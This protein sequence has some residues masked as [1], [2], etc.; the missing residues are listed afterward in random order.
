[1]QLKHNQDF[2]NYQIYN[3]LLNNYLWLQPTTLFQDVD[4]FSCSKTEASLLRKRANFWGG[5]L[6]PWLKTKA[7]AASTPG[8]LSQQNWLAKK[9]R[10]R[11]VLREGIVSWKDHCTVFVAISAGGT[12]AA[13]FTANVREIVQLT[14]LE[15]MLLYIGFFKK[16]VFKKG[17]DLEMMSSKQEE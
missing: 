5:W 11:P 7:S 2:F 8:Q 9:T 15:T 14:C 10:H 13:K 1:M 6:L 3:Y 4:C 17:I 12:V 16:A